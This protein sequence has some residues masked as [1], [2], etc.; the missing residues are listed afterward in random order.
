MKRIVYFY[1]LL[2]ILVKYSRYYL[3]VTSDDLIWEVSE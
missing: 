2:M 3:L 1:H